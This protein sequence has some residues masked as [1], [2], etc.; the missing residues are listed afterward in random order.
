MLLS[1][2]SS[3]RRSTTTSNSTSAVYSSKKPPLQSSRRPATKHDDTSSTN[4]SI[5]D[6]NPRSSTTDS[7][8]AF[9]DDAFRDSVND[10]LQHVHLSVSSS[11]L[12]EATCI[13]PSLLFPVC[14]EE[15]VEVAILLFLPCIPRP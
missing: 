4:A 8:Q 3:Q 10:K 12:S 14:L 13:Q 15:R 6:H 7:S 2:S 5:Q 1:I 9:V 11:M